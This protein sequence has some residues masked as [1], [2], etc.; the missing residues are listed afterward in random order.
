MGKIF[1]AYEVAFLKAISFNPI[2][3]EVSKS[4]YFSGLDIS[5]TGNSARELCV[6]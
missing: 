1:L 3:S 5:P 2:F 6:C 4:P